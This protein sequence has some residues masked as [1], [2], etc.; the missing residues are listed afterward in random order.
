M[1][2]VLPPVSRD[3]VMKQ[4]LYLP[5]AVLTGAFSHTSIQQ[6]LV[7]IGLQSDDRYWWV[8]Y[9]GVRRTAQGTLMGTYLKLQN[10]R[11]NS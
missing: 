1:E 2:Q 6:T 8:K 3:A 11:K 4:T 7:G 9:G 5:V 10:M